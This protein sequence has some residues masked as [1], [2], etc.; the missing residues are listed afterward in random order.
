M[1][2]TSST[3]AAAVLC[4]LLPAA[5]VAQIAPAP[6]SPWHAAA[7]VSREAGW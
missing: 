6:R 1:F 7:D 4:L 5:A 3:V 2:R